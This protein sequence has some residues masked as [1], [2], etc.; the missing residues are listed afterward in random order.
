MLRWLQPRRVLEIGSGNSTRVAVA[1]LERN[2][3][4][5]ILSIEPFPS[6]MLKRLPITLHSGF[7]QDFDADFFNDTLADGDVLFIDS[8]HTVKASSDCCHLYLRVLPRLRRDL[9]VHVHDIALPQGISVTNAVEKH[10]Y[11]TEQYLLA[12]LLT[13]NPKIDFLLGVVFANLRHRQ[14]LLAMM[15]GKAGPGGASFWFRLHGDR[16]VRK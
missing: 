7:A 14:R 15:D 9:V 5:D 10:I 16:P 3:A 6:D 12:A 13:D 4:G 1:A 2:G 11:W 8:T